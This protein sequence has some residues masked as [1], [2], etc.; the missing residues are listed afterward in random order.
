MPADADAV[1]PPSFQPSD[2]NRADV[3]AEVRAA[4]EH[5]EAALLRNDADALNRFFLDH[6]DTVRYGIA[7]H[8]VGIEAIR[9]SRKIAPPVYPGRRLDHTVI[10]TFGWNA[11]SVCTEFAAPEARWV[12]R[13]T[14]S[15][16]RIDGVWRI[17]AAHVSTVD[18]QILRRC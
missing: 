2:I 10:T 4:F 5:Y 16:I 14:Q 15:W 18:R 17:V 8:A 1:I 6:D 9:Q 7:E 12:G 3:V 13:Q 11:A